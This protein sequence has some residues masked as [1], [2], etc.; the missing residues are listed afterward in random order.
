MWSDHV[1]PMHRWRGQGGL[2]AGERRRDSWHHGLQE[3][4]SR[5]PRDAVPLAVAQLPSNSWRSPLPGG[6][7]RA[8]SNSCDPTTG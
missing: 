6:W 5:T 1:P 3:T 7:Q 8:L 4:P 2:D